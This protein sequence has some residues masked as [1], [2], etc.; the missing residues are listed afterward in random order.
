[1]SV[2]RRTIYYV[3]TLLLD[4]SCSYPG[5]AS[6]DCRWDV[7]VRCAHVFTWLTYHPNQITFFHVMLST[8]TAPV[9]I[10]YIPIPFPVPPPPSSLALA[11]RVQDQSVPGK[12]APVDASCTNTWPPC[13]SRHRHCFLR[14]R[15][16]SPSSTVGGALFTAPRASSRARSRWRRNVGLTF[17]MRVEMLL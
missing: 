13:L 14:G 10:D 15:S 12:E 17:S 11:S 8:H 9:Y 2:A 16:S 7:L 6:P 3:H 5:N 4:R 1:M